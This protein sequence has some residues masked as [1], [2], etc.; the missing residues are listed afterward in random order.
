MFLNGIGA[1]PGIAMGKAL[2]V[3]DNKPIIEKK[4]VDNVD[5]EIDRL[6][7]AVEISKYEMEEL[8]NKASK[9]LPYD[10]AE[11]V[12]NHLSILDNSDLIVSSKE[13]L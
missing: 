11:L 1:S 7:R 4:I 13:N 8:K 9:E 3:V 2:V 5:Y 10:E 12:R 6:D